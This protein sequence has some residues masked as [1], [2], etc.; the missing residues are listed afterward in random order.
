MEKSSCKVDVDAQSRA[1][2]CLG[3]ELDDLAFH[4][5][6]EQLPRAPRVRLLRLRA[7]MAIANEPLH[8][9]ATVAR[10]A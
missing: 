3:N 5:R 7:V 9:R 10:A 4:Q 2:F 1:L 6:T 8:R